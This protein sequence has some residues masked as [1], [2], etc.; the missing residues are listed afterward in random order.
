MQDH[1][2]KSVGYTTSSGSE[3]DSCLQCGRTEEWHKKI[4]QEPKRPSYERA[5][6][7]LTQSGYKGTTFY[8]LAKVLLTS[9]IEWTDKFEGER[10][11]R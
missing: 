10:V 11:Y 8:E 4:E 1:Q 2:F 7:W 9:Y 5:D 6:D 3:Q